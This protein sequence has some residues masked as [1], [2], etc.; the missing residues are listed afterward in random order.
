MQNSSSETGSDSV[1]YKRRRSSVHRALP[2]NKSERSWIHF[3]SKLTSIW[4]C[5][6]DKFCL[7]HAVW[8]VHPVTGDGLEIFGHGEEERD[9]S[10][11]LT[12]WD[13]NRNMEIDT[14]TDKQTD[15]GDGERKK[16][17]GERENSKFGMS[18]T[19]SCM[20]PFI[21]PRGR[22]RTGHARSEYDHEA[23]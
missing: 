1:N 6:G 15:R 21:L 14:L 10:V 9:D 16:W 17:K 4:V 23:R 12:R 13:R 20:K 5:S 2:K 3:S 11:S 18:T 7:Y 19:D 22:I 8:N